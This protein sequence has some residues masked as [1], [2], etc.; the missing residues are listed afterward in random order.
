MPANPMALLFLHDPVAYACRAVR[1]R[2]DIGTTT[3]CCT[4]SPPAESAE[5]L[6]PLLDRTACPR[7]H[8]GPRGLYVANLVGPV[9]LLRRERPGTAESRAFARSP[10]KDREPRRQTCC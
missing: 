8:S 2:M 5:S 9:G 10:G 7:L 4:S 1:H 6:R 3:S